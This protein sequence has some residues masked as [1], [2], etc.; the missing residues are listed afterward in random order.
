MVIPLSDSS[1]SDC[2]FDFEVLSL[3]IVSTTFYNLRKIDRILQNLLQLGDSSCGVRLCG[4]GTLRLLRSVRSEVL[5]QDET[6]LHYSLVF[7][8]SS[9]L[10]VLCLVLEICY[11]VLCPSI[12]V[13]YPLLFY[14][15]FAVIDCVPFF[16]TLNLTY[17]VFLIIMSYENLC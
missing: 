6:P 13:H 15:I 14:I 1:Q 16:S 2:D 9:K 4:F 17:N 11:P 10:M 12:F 8:L 5:H 3:S 7:S